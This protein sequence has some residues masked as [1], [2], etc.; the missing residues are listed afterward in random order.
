MHDSLF[1]WHRDGYGCFGD[2]ENFSESSMIGVFA[3][4]E[5]RRVV[6]MKGPWV[7]SNSLLKRLD[8]RYTQGQEGSHKLF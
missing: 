2:V 3:Y 7:E 4:E 1:L 8:S 6:R 5:R